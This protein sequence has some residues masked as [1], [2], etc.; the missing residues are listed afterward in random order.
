VSYNKKSAKSSWRT[1]SIAID[2]NSQLIAVPKEAYLSAVTFED[3]KISV[4]GKFASDL[5]IIPADKEVP[6]APDLPELKLMEIP[7][8]P[9]DLKLP[10]G[11]DY[12]W[13]K[14]SLQKFIDDIDDGSDFSKAK[15][16]GQL[17]IKVSDIYPSENSL[18]IGLAFK[19][20]SKIPFASVAGKAFIK[21]SLSFVKDDNSGKHTALFDVEKLSFS[22]ESSMKDLTIIWAAYNA[23]KDKVEAEFSLDIDR[24]VKDSEAKIREIASKFRNTSSGNEDE[25][26]V[27]IVLG[28]FI[29]AEKEVL[30]Y[31][32]AIAK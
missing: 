27:Q 28:D 32:S 3:N 17:Q 19:S 24:Q 1:L 13:I 12:D 14:G 18:A 10:L 16:N 26:S 2:E 6:Q 23:L 9:F 11:L 8:V 20:K 21:T 25:L 29:Y 30:V 4:G 5:T 7:D 15:N 31:T 22:S